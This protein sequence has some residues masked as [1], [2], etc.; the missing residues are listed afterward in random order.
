MGTV[1]MSQ[2]WMLRWVVL[3]VELQSVQAGFMKDYGEATTVSM[4][5]TVTVEP[6][7]D[8]QSTI[9]S[10]WGNFHFKTFDGYF[11]QVPDTC[12]YILAGL[13]NSDFNIKMQRKM[14]ELPEKYQ[15]QTG[16]L[17]GN[18]NGNKTDDSVDNGFSLA[19]WK[20]NP[21]ESCEDIRINPN[22]QCEIQTSVCQQYLS[23]P[24]FSDCYDV[25]DMSSFEKACVD[26]LCRC[27]GDEDCLCNTLTEISR[28][29]T[30]AGGKPGTWRTEQLCP[31]SCPLNMQ[32]LE[33]GNPCK[34]TC[35]DPD[36]SLLCKDHCVDGC[37]CPDGMVEDDIGQR[38]CV[39]VNECQCKHNDNIYSSGESYTQ[40]CR[41]CVCAAGHWTCTHLDC[42]GIC[43]VV[44]GSHV[45]TY[46]G[47][48]FTFSGNCDYIL[49]KHSDDSDIAVV[50][51]LA[52]CEP[53]IPG[54]ADT[55]LNSVTLVIPWATI[56]FSS[57]GVVTRNEN[58]PFKLPATEGPV[59]IFQPSSSFI[60]A[61]MKSLRLEIQ[62]APVMQLY[63]VASTEEKGKLSGL[64]GNYNDIQKDDF[65]TDSGITEGTPISFVNF[66]KKNPYSCPDLEN[67][68]DNPCSMHSDTVT[69]CPNN[70]KYTYSVTSCSGTCRSLSVQDNTCQGSFTPVDGCVCSEGTYLNEAGS[71]VP[72]D[73]C[74]CY[75]KNQVIKPSEII[76]NNGVECICNLGQLQCSRKECEAPMVFF[77]CSNY[78]QG[79]KGVECQR[80]CEKQDPNNCVST[81]C[82]S[83]CMCPDDLLADGN[84]GCV[85]RKNCFC[86]HNGVTY[87]PG[88]QVQEECNNCTCTNG[89]WICT[90]KVCYGTCTI[91]GEGHFKTF[92]GSI[93]SF[94]GDC[95]HILVQDYCNMDQTPSFRLVTEN[96]FCETTSTI[97]KSI[98]LLFG[99][100]EIHLSEDGVKI[101]KNNDTDYEYEIHSAGIYIVTE[102]KGLLNLI[103][104]NKTSLMLQLHPK[105]KGKVCGLCGNFDGNANNDFLKHNGEVVTNPDE[106]GNSWKVNPTCPDVTNVI[107]LCKEYSHRSVWAE[108]RCSIIRSDVFKDCH[109]LV[110]STQYYDNCKTDTCTC[111]SGGD[112]DCFCTAVAAY[113]AECRKK[114]V[115]VAWRTPSICP[116]FC[117][118]YN[119]PGECEW[120][121]NSC[122]PPCPKTCRNPTGTCSDQIPLLEGCFLQC[123]PETP[124]LLDETMTCV[125]QCNC[126]YNNNSF[127]A[128]TTVYHT[129]YENGTCSKDV[130]MENGEITRFNFEHC[131]STTTTTTTTPF[132]TTSTTTAVTTTTP[133]ISTTTTTE[134]PTTTTETPSTTTETP[135]STTTVTPPSTT[136]ETPSTTIVTPPSTTTETPSTTTVTPPSTTTETPST[137]TVTPPSTTSETPSTTTVTPPSTT[138]TTETP[139][140]T[141]TVTPPS[142]TTTETPSTTTITPPS[143]TTTTETPSTTTVTPPSTTTTTETPSTTTTVTPSYTTTETPS[144]TTVTPPSTTTETPS[145]TTVTPP[146]TTT[147]TPSTTT[148]T[149]PSTTTE[150]PS[151]TTVTPPSTTTETPS[152]TTVTPPSTTTETPSTTT[153]TP[154]STTTETPSTTTVT[155]PSTTTETPSTT[156]VIPPSTTTETPSTTTVTPPSTTT[157]TPST[158]HVSPPSTTT[159]TPSTTTVTPPSTTTETP[160]TTTTV[161]PPSTT[162]ETPS[163]TTVTPPSTTTETPSTTT[164]TPPSTTTETPYTT[165]TT[166]TPPSTTTETPSTTTVTPPSTTTETPSTTTVT[167]P[168][169]ILFCKWS[170]WFDNSQASTDVEG[171]EIESISELWKLNEISCERPDKI[172]CMTN[173]NNKNFTGK[174]W[175]HN[176]VVSCNTS[177]GLLC[178]NKENY[179]Q[180]CNNHLIRV[181]CTNQSSSTTNPTSTTTTTETPPSTTTETP[182]TTTTVTPPS[183]TTET[184]STT[185][186]TPP[187]E[188]LFCKWSEW[189]DN[190]QAS[191]DVEGQ[192]IESISELWKLNEISCERPDKIECMTNYNNK[193]FTGKKWTHNQVVSCNTSYGLLCSN[194]EN[195]PQFCNNHLIRVCCTNQS[196]S[197]TNPTSTTTTTETPP[198]KTTE[199]PSTTTVTPPSTTTET[200]STTTVTPSTKTETPST[201]TVTPPS[202]TTETHSTTTETP[203]STKTETP[204]TTSV[205]PPSTATE[206]PSTTVTPPSTTTE[207]P[208]TVTPSYTTTETPSTTTVTPPSTTTETP[209]TT[210]VTP[211]ST[212][213]E[214]PFTTTVTPPSTTTETP[215]TTTVTPPSTTTETPSTISVTP[216]STTTETPFTTTVTPPSTTAETPST[217]T[218]TPLTITTETPST[219]TVTPPST[220]TETPSTTTVTPPSTTTETPSTTTVT[221]PSTTTETPSTTTVTPP[222]TTTETPSTTTV[223]PPSTTTETPSTTTVTP[224]ST[225]TETPST[226]SVTPPSTTTETPFT[227]TV[228]PPSTTTETPSTTTVTPPSTT[229]ETPSTTTV[230]PPSTT[231]E[232]PSTISVTPPSTTTETPF[233]TTVTPPSTTTKTPSTTTVTPPSTT[234]ETPSTTTVTP[235]STTTETPSTI[236]VTPPS[237]TTETPFTTTVTPPSTTTE[238][239]STTTVTP[240]S[241]TTETPSTTTVTPPSTT[242]EPPSTT[243]VTPPSTTTETP[244]TISVTPPSTTTETPSTTTVTPP[245]TTTET[246]STTTVTPPSTTTETPS[247]TTVTP[248]PTTTETPSTTT[249]VTPP[250][251][252]TETP[253]TTTTVTPPFTTTETPST[254]T[255]TP[256]STTTETPS[257]TTVTPPSTTT[258]TPSTTTVTPPSTTTETPS[259]ISVTPP[260]TTAETPFT[261]TVTPPSTTTKTPS[262]TTVTPPST[263]IETPS[264]TTVTPLTITTETP[265]TT[266]VT[267]PSTTT[268]TPSTTTVTPPSTTT[269]TPST[270]SVTPP[271]T[272]T[273]TPFTTTVT[274]PS[275]TT[276]TTSTTTITPPS[277]T[278]ETPSTTTVTPLTIT[279][280]TPSTTTVTPPS[281]TTETPSTTTVTPPSTTTETPSTTTVTPPS[282][283]TETPSTTTVTP[284]ST[285]TETPSTTTVTPPS[286][287]TE[288]PSTISVTP[289]STTTETPF[290]TTV[291]PPSTT[292]ETPS[293][294]TVTPPSTTTETPFTTTVTPPSTTTETPS[295]ISVTPPSITT[296]TPFTTTVTP[297]STTTE[298]P[299]TTT[300]TPPS[301][302]TET[303]STTTVT[304]PST[305]TETPSTTTVTPPSTTTET[306]STISVTPPSTTT[307]T[308]F[309]TTVTPPSTTTKTP[310]TTTITPPSTT[311]ETPSTTTVTPLTITTETPS[312]TTVTPPST[313][314]ETPSTTTVTPPSTTTETPSTTTVTPP[315]TTTETPSTTTVT[316]PS[317]TTETPSTTT[318]TPPS[319]TTETPSTT[320]VTPPSTTT[321]TP[322]TTTV[323]PPS[324]TT[325]TP[326]TISVTP[327]SIT[328]ETPFTTTVTPPSTTTETPSTTT[329]TPPST[330]TETPSTTTVTPPSTTTETPFTTT[331]TPPSTTTETPSTTTVTPPST[332]TET[333]ST[334]TV[335]PPSTTT[336]TPSTTTVTPPSTTTETP[337]TTTTIV[338][339]TTPTK[340]TTTTLT[341]SS[342]K[343]S[344]TATPPSTT[345]GTSTTTRTTT[346]TTT[347]STKSTTTCFCTHGNAKYPVGST[348]Y[349]LQDECYTAYCNSSCDIVKQI[350]FDNHTTNACTIKTCKGG[351]VVS[352]PVYCE[353]IIAVPKCVN[354][355]DPVKVYYNDGCCFKYECECLCASWG[356][357]H[358]RTFDGQYY[359][360]QGNCTYVLFEE[361]IPRYN[362]SVHAKNYF[363]DL[364]NN[365]ACPEYV[366][367]YYKSYKIKITSDKEKAIN[368]YVNNVKEKPTYI[369]DNMI[370]TSTGIEVTLNISEIKTLIK[371]SYMNV[372]IKLPFSYFHHN[373][374]GQCGFCDNSTIDDCRLPNGTIDKSCERV[375]PFWT[376]PPGCAP[377][378]PPPTP[379]PPPSP[380]VIC[381]IINSNV[382]KSCHDVVP[383]QDYYEACKYDVTKMKNDSAACSS[384]EAYAQLCGDKSIC[385]DWRNSPILKGLC[386]YKCPINKVYKACGPEVEKSCSTSYNAMYGD[387]ECK[388]CKQTVNEGC[389]CPDGQYRVNRTSNLCTA[390]CDCIDHDGLPRQP[391]DTWT[392]QCETYNCSKFGTRLTEPIKC[393]TQEPCGDEYKST[394]I[395]CCPTCVCDLE[396]CL[397]KKCDVGFEL[398]SNK[399]EDSCCPPCVPKDV[400]VYNN[401]EYQVGEVHSYGCETFTC[402][403][404]NG[405]FVIKNITECGSSDCQPGFK[406]VK[407]DGECCGECTQV[408]CV[409]VA[410]DA[411]THT[412]QVGEVHSYKCENVTCREID[413]SLI[414]DRS[415]EKCSYSSSSDCN[416][417]FKYEENDE[418]CCGECTQVACVYIASDGT[419][420]TLQVGEVHSYKCEN[421]TCLEIDGSL[422]TDRSS[423]KCSYSSSSDCNLGFKYEKKDGE[424]CG[425]CTQVACVYVASDGTTQ[426]L[427]VGEV[428]SYKCENVTC[429]E[430]DGSLITDRSSEKC[431]YSSSSDCN[432][433]FK[434]EKKDGECCGE[435][436]QVACV[437]VA[438]DSTTQ[439]LQVGEVHSYKCENITCLEIDGSLITDRS[440]EKCSYSS[441]SDC[442]P[443]FKYEEKDGEC[444]GE[445]TQVA[446]VYVAPDGTTH[447]LQDR[448]GYKV[449]CTTGI[450]NKVNDAFVIVENTREC[451]SFN[452]EDCKPGTIQFDSDGCCITCEPM[453]CVLEK[454]VTRL[455][456]SDCISINDVE[457]SSCAGHC[458]TKSM[459]SMEN[460]VMM[461]SCSCCREAEVKHQQVTLKCANNTEISYN[462]MYVE[463]CTCTPTKCVDT[464]TP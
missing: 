169:E 151:T 80:T 362:I 300:V 174:K 137:T 83:G 156:T 301:T 96:K 313:T 276:K 155:P 321:E 277:T 464:K 225:T 425:E 442:N 25:L 236:S 268:E 433:G 459:Y 57:S 127:T 136:T 113:A 402:H 441:S 251:T 275:T 307:E 149:P 367:V 115:C 463:S 372:Q 26:D 460:N 320:T 383:H 84:G 439:T 235:P 197:T 363:C 280:E 461:H 415:S 279:T 23:S 428:H 24:G 440:S 455:H 283:T 74:P 92:D 322:S 360:F 401:T 326:S 257:T 153:V 214:T 330:T 343:S 180:F 234:T 39:P 129:S 348:I 260:S 382:F 35:S 392:N 105:L 266:T 202:T 286:T 429:L 297:P 385:V 358:Y 256:P 116:L 14:I 378:P 319:T 317:T 444:C 5:Q 125:K 271:S 215:S 32:Y 82:E 318:V 400:C 422:I 458:D 239:P 462:Y 269:E 131:D 272:T 390:Y 369:N 316:P 210:T 171:Q 117:D 250:S 412:L 94:H 366:L 339:T 308:P 73:Q 45:T 208:T 449:K 351:K 350:R 352:E 111:D 207:T 203:P 451:P 34:N 278:T 89:M 354:G 64:C 65:K 158:T 309:T 135:S 304:P 447:T 187:P 290:T 157:E 17:C 123:P 443:G 85:E 230:T 161:T 12:D 435:C 240:P 102:V 430:I 50:G 248:P 178:S 13:D 238:T 241:T 438:P 310:S 231:T 163:T 409:Y 48:S 353:P 10:T 159:E 379:P 454:N 185:T 407:K 21:S 91:Y 119:P 182:S 194:K 198:S 414:T 263:T 387:N 152:T 329:V 448:E 384:V 43:S 270:I 186:V 206:T 167:P 67:T 302:T 121:Y 81:G 179:P 138:T 133:T 374:R 424:C 3:L 53:S 55:C 296:E 243:T 386:D 150:T 347:T 172:E 253:S 344:T 445:C 154:P 380:P 221:P 432:L 41:T 291:T 264:T 109:A 295:T 434:Y 311:T 9:C 368:V 140:T 394:I 413:G 345:T 176:Q 336:E 346:V 118:Y 145:T 381:G 395:N 364:K 15:G 162:T 22:D 342:T 456:V 88:D 165:T 104:D 33:C 143:T 114:G 101:I 421:V 8:H 228:T 324:T 212:T 229:T 166:V 298:T 112:C 431:S 396:R 305:T 63:I 189:F 436:T 77:N 373:T 376:V 160:S 337:S 416:L 51:N 457:V 36:A 193:N 293:T 56:S 130:C 141:T 289:P 377:P 60:I 306:P 371:V 287:T 258:E 223:T 86:V 399:T 170:E 292:T 315:S 7:P 68:F 11:F 134:T 452:P 218:V 249:T 126:T 62:L 213:T 361:I 333:P 61:D 408:A 190:S 199:T 4:D 54:Q 393:P 284:P 59:S 2:M 196:S 66:W 365:L 375:A 288:T 195:Y 146:S 237:T 42:P 28:E 417:G 314:T 124:Y 233:T 76:Y 107:D 391:G 78:E 183:T 406:Y 31:K 75:Y 244:S 262:T 201:T 58:S 327:P 216:P 204:S 93:Y 95:E 255:V 328:T 200:P 259:T 254:T 120:G 418:E 19:K 312:T 147:E 103:W 110:D 426:T 70:M 79:H 37:F 148:V 128:G 355:L 282:T 222:S 423:E 72:A 331:V 398:A 27:Y 99:L 211:P 144:T 450:C 356:D 226:I 437:Y 388:D 325:E 453:N 40:A 90:K 98:S 177:Y 6:N 49:T 220:T 205:T 446:C 71:C 217:T 420:Q 357:P 419:T 47:K 247:T 403:R 20:V 142:T 261:T 175:T 273:E 274:P 191:T 18:F 87:S 227:T 349:P 219:T 232:T 303:P 52:Q 173:Y 242:T 404:S 188:I 100:N 285:T 389:Y 427:Q 246:P 164:V 209:S 192:E 410:P 359:A 46:D 397:Q 267:P 132:T 281:T 122:G 341:P 44:G 299:S 108:K 38:G 323:T 224:P 106:F 181:C 16:G 29:C 245:S 30:H 252:T 139:S 370:I 294:T 97:C 332:T 168:P 340:S 335:T 1:R 265:S 338:T 405:M 69:D 411:T 184:P 334:T